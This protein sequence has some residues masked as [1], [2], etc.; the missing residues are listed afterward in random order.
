MSEEKKCRVCGRKVGDNFTYHMRNLPA[1]ASVPQRVKYILY[2]G[3]CNVCDA[4]FARIDAD[5]STQQGIIMDM[6]DQGIP[7]HQR[8]TTDRA[9]RVRG[10]RVGRTTSGMGLSR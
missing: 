1:R 5:V 10:T 2:D 3:R 7:A 9:Q 4:L 6:F 8:F